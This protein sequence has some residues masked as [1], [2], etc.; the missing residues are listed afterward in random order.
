MA[1]SSIASRTA[2]TSSSFAGK[3]AKSSAPRVGVQSRKPARVM[4]NYSPRTPKPSDGMGSIS[5]KK[6]LV[7]SRRPAT[8]AP[9]LIA[10]V[11]ED[12]E[13]TQTDF[14]AETQLP[15]HGGFYR[16]R[17]YR[18]WVNGFPT[19]P[20]AIVHGDVE[21][22]E[23]VPVRVH[24][25]CFTSEVL[26]S[27]K[28]DCAE[29]LN[30]ALK[31]IQE[32]GPGIVVYLQQEGRG[33]GLANKIA[34][35]MMQEQGHDTVDANRV[36]GLPDDCREYTAVASMIKDMNIKSIKLITNNPRKIN[37]LTDLGVNV[38]D[39]IPCLID[40]NHV[41]DGYLKAKASRMDHLLDHL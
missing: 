13:E 9:E 20:L 34:A 37:C 40:S 30:L 1:M 38:A 14:I 5:A 17:A 4:A 27:M 23:E 22:M 2:L 11:V 7:F 25:A 28:C 19:E 21:G 35:Y 8:E 12:I 32:N 26:G 18:H 10:P 31:Y 15:T 6:R 36:L 39:R 41:N 29:Q 16:V 24:D 3:Q 33:I